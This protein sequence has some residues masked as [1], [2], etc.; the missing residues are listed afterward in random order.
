MMAVANPALE[1]FVAQ[2]GPELVLAQV[3]MRRRSAGFELRHAD[4]RA[5]PQAELRSLPLNGLRALAQFTA[6]GA[7]RP[8]NSAPNLQTGCRPTTAHDAAMKLALNH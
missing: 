2:L 1:K 5:R 4:D 6:D 8:L 7:L 3:L